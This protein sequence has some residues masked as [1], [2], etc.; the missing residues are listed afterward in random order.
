MGPVH[1]H[2]QVNKAEP[3]PLLEAI[4]LFPTGMDYEKAHEDITRMAANSINSQPL[5]PTYATP[6]PQP[7]MPIPAPQGKFPWR[8]G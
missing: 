4:H 7:L 8:T 6:M 1:S 3:T 5:Q 2:L